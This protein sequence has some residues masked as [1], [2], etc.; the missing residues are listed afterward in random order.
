[1]R[2]TQ[3]AKLQCTEQDKNMLVGIS[4]SKTAPHREVVRAGILLRYMEGFSITAIAENFKT[5]RPLVERCLNKAIAFGIHTALRDLPGRGVKPMITDDARSWVLSVACQ[6]PKLLGY[7]NETWTYSLLIKYIR[8]N[9]EQAGYGSLLKIDKGVLHTILAKGKIQPHK[10]RYYLER[11]D[12]EFDKKMANVLQVYKQV[13]L[14]NEMQIP[15]R[16]ITTLSYDE[17][18]GIQAIKHTAPQL[19]PVVKEH[20]TIQ[21]DHEYERLGTVSLLA[22]I[23]LHTGIVIPIVRDQHR[24]KEFIEFLSEIDNHYPKDWLIRIILDNHSSHVSKET[25]SWLLTRPGRF[26]FVFTP[27]HGS[28]LNMIEMFFSKVA[29]SFLR[30]I[31]V[32]SK[33]ELVERIYQGI[34]EINKDPVIFRWKY[35]M[36]EVELI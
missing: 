23:D 19:Q 7:A 8:A 9:C 5:N 17:K 13:E 26:E 10:V 15:D 1:M 21:R 20:S 25:T 35:K 14:T 18:P 33:E 16:G 29:R 3:K 22:G 6:P 4:K 24:S 27:K 31:R 12:V 34:E 28:W 30:H 2:K 32:E 11:R 36:E